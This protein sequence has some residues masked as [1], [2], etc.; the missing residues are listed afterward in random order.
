[1]NPAQP[2]VSIITPSYNQRP[3]L[4][5][6]IRSVLWQDYQPLEY[7]LID[8]GST[9][10]SLELIR[11]YAPRLA[12]WVSEPDQGQAD[13]IN[14]GFRQAHGEFVAWINSDDVYYRQDVISQA[15]RTLQENPQ[16]G[17][18]YGDGVMVD[19]E[20]R[21]LDW[22]AYPQYGLVDLLG[23]NVLLQPAVVMRRTVL[24]AAGF[25][26]R[27]YHLILDHLLW[28]EMAARAPIL[29]FP[30]TW[31]VERTHQAAKT[32]AQAARFVDE[33]FR[34]AAEL[35]SQPLFAPVFSDHGR[36]I[37]GGLHVFAGKR[38]ID[39]GEPRRA[40]RH[41]W[42]AGRISPRVMA[43]SW[44]KAV[45][46][47]GGALG[48]TGLFLAYRR[49]RRQVQHPAQRL[50]VDAEGVRWEAVG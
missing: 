46:A 24:E 37:R 36:T 31:A 29:H 8:G 18:V 1:M 19:A 30:Q 35:E 5:Q 11:E 9:D 17:M 12:Y 44:Y 42:T 41:F 10:G 26:R 34:A 3:Y 45:Q 20:G 13:A 32:M 48:L 28:I 25:L 47:L 7:I 50:V 2:L 4:E 15:V 49:A 27:D 6:T 21:L 39:A 16:A 38:L 23:F 43:K 22:H 33:A 14:K 40:L